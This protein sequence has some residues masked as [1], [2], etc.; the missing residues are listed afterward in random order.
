MDGATWCWHQRTT[1]STLCISG[2]T[3]FYRRRYPKT[4]ACA[5]TKPMWWSRSQRSQRDLTKRFDE[6]EIDWAIIEKQ[7]VAWKQYF[8]KGKKLRIDISFHYAETGRQSVGSSLKKSDKRGPVSTTQRMLAERESQLDAEEQSS[9]QPSIWREV[10]SVMRCPG[11]PCN[12]GSYCWIDSEGKRHYK[13]KTHHLRNLIRYVEKGGIPQT[14]DD[15]PDDIREQLYAEEQQRHDRKSGCTTTSPPNLPPISITNVLPGLAH[16]ASPPASQLRAVDATAAECLDI[17][18]LRDVALRRYTEWQQSQVEDTT[19][20]DEFRNAYNAAMTEGLSLEQVH[21]H[22][23]PEFF[24]KQ[25]VKR[26]PAEHFVHDILNWS[27]R[28]K[29]DCVQ[30]RVD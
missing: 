26:G 16:Q 10:Y 19:L 18:G 12:L 8:R 28:Y 2:S 13:L 21:K 22:Q 5:L 11:P 17:P 15:V 6:T 29:K 7:L 23:D 4:E 25:G 3:N 24:R 30:D 9:G 20:K 27:K 1:G 14:H